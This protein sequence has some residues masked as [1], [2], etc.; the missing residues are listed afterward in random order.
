MDNNTIKKVQYFCTYS[1]GRTNKRPVRS[2]NYNSMN[3]LLSAM[4]SYLAENPWTTVNYQ[5]ETKYF[6]QG[7]Q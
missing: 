1:N 2:R 5:T 3:E 4:A 7:A 6:K